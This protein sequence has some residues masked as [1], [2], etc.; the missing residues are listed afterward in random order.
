MEGRYVL[1]HITQLL[2]HTLAFLVQFALQDK[3][4]VVL[5]PMEQ[6]TILHSAFARQMFVLLNVSLEK[7]VFLKPVLASLSC[8]HIFKWF[9][10]VAHVL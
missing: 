6:T 8:N 3:F 10:E 1:T 2:E 5:P 7:L 9:Q 4:P